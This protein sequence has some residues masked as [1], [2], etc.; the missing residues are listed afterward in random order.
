MRLPLD[1]NVTV[2]AIIADGQVLH[3]DV[4]VVA[5]AREIEQSG[6]PFRRIDPKLVTYDGIASSYGGP[7]DAFRYTDDVDYIGTGHVW[8]GRPKVHGEVKQ[9]TR[10]ARCLGACAPP[11]DLPSTTDHQQGSVFQTVGGSSMFRVG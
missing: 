3:A 9:S 4:E 11:L 1:D 8:R 7:G 6:V 2:K 5:L 10:V